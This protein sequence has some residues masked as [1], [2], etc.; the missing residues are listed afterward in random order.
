VEVDL[1]VFATDVFV[2]DGEALVSFAIEETAACAMGEALAEL[3]PFTELEL[4]TVADASAGAEELDEAAVDADPVAVKE[5]A[6]GAVE[7]E[8]VVFEEAAPLSETVK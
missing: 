8:A 6:A 1:L 4:F 5:A 7:F 2:T 3:K